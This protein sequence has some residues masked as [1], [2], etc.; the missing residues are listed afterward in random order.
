MSEPDLIPWPAWLPRKYGE[1]VKKKSGADWHGVICGW[2]RTDLTE[3]GYAV[4]S[5]YERNAVQV[6][7]A[8]ALVSM[9][10][11]D[12]EQSGVRAEL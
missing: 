1:C 3:V 5:I 2:Y 4:R 6:F 8:S 10:R 9:E 11:P 12:A 7:P